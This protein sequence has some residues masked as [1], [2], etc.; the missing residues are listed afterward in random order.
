M[1]APRPFDAEASAAIPFDRLNTLFAN[2]AAEYGLP[3][4]TDAQG[5]AWVQIGK[6]AIGL[7]PEG[8]GCRVLARADSAD[9]LF[10]LQEAAVEHLAGLNP[11]LRLDWSDAP[12]AGATPPNFS[13]A[14]VAGVRQLTPHFLRL[15]L[16]SDRLDRLARDMIHFRLVLPQPSG[17]PLWPRLDADGKTAWPE[18][19]HRPAYTVAAIDPANGWLETDIFIHDGGR[20]CTFAGQA[21]VGAQVGLN[22]PGGGGIPQAAHL[23]LAGD[24]TAYPAMARIAAAQAPGVRIDLTLLGGSRDYPFAARPGLTITHRPA[25]EDALARDLLTARPADFYWIA[26]E[27]GRLKPLKQAVSEELAIPKDRSHLAAYWTA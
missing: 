3:R 8:A 15:R 22:G 7:R 19:L 1:T 25:A 14:R 21:V 5:A 18:G 2:L 24:E 17:P 23:V 27:K 4:Q 10:T 16:E 12:R 9:W 6:G 26:T 13:L 11:A 20:A